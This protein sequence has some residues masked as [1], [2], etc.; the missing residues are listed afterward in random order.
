MTSSQ[1]A[2]T[3]S[4]VFGWSYYILPTD[5]I[6]TTF[7]GSGGFPAVSASG[8]EASITTDKPPGKQPGDTAGNDSAH[9]WMFLLKY[10]IPVNNKNPFAKS[11]NHFV[12][13]QSMLII[14]SYQI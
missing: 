5:G 8:S 1:P 10:Y 11:M 4:P 2:H 9:L 14:F 7:Y 3:S 13:A 6:A 12:S